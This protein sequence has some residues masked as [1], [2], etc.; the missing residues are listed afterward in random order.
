MGRPTEATIKRL[1]ALSGNLCAFPDCPVLLVEDAGA[2]IGEIC[3][4]RAEK[5]KGPRFDPAWSATEL[6][7]FD[8][9]IVLCPTH[10][11]IIDKK[12]GQFTV[13]VLAQM[14]AAH[15]RANGRPER[16]DDVFAARILL[17]TYDRISVTGD[18]ANVVVN[19]P[20]AIVGQTV[21]VR[22]ASSKVKIQPP[23]G[24]IGTDELTCRYIEYLIK[25]YNEF[26][27]ADKHRSRPFSYGA[28]S[29]TIETK[30]R[31]RWRSLPLADF[32]P[33][34]DYLQWRINRTRVAK[35]N[36]A[37]GHRSFSSFAEFTNS[38]RS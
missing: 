35:A 36:T 14:K 8:N 25:R 16:A 4:I 21:N 19:S 30:F 18:N 31:G 27:G 2:S 17:R 1:Y 38:E 7:S 22:T 3:H 11:T 37:K 26:A 5:P 12:P 33:V 9:L 28:I 23:P 29:R 34:V 20:G 6:G 15:Q 24:T 32:D 13:E 10:H